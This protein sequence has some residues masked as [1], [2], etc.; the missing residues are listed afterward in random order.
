M[1]LL[2][3]APPD[4]ARAI[5]AGDI[6]LLG[7]D[8]AEDDSLESALDTAR[9]VSVDCVVTAWMLEDGDDARAIIDRLGRVAGLPVVVWSS[10]PCAIAWCRAHGEKVV[11]GD[12]TAEA[13]LAVVLATVAEVRAEQ[14]PALDAVEAVIGSNDMLPR[15]QVQ[16]VGAICRRAAGG[17]R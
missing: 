5:L 13:L 15:E 16:L 9:T 2:L 7:H 17:A 4:K 3:I 1:N 6:E 14:L 11:S 10:D 8:V 12:T